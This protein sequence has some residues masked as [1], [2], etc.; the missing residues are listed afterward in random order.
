MLSEV[1][2]V[3]SILRVL[4][5]PEIG[6]VLELLNLEYGDVSESSNYVKLEDRISILKDWLSHQP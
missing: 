2:A 6:G 3:Q 5:G 4:Q 1:L